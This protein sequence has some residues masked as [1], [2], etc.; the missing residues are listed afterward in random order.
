MSRIFVDV[1]KIIIALVLANQM[2]AP[3]KNTELVQVPCSRYNRGCVFFLRKYNEVSHQNAWLCSE[4][5]SSRFIDSAFC[6]S[7][8][9]ELV[10]VFDSWLAKIRIW[11]TY[12]NLKWFTWN[13]VIVSLFSPTTNYSSAVLP[14]FIINCM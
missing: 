9:T 7:K 12:N 6:F 2:I 11:L 5:F 14:Y 8:F 4:V 13:R 1:N 10:F 3:Q